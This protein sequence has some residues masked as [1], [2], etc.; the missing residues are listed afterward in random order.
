[1]AIKVSNKGD[2]GGYRT[3]IT[4]LQPFGGAGLSASMFLKKYANIAYSLISL[5]IFLILLLISIPL[6]VLTLEVL[7]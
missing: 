4:P 5:N 2:G 6:R 3:S 1:M 7:L